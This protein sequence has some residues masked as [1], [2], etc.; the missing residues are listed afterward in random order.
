MPS[1]GGLQMD[2]N[3]RR[4]KFRLLRPLFEDTMLTS[5]SKDSLIPL[6]SYTRYSHSLEKTN[7][8]GVTL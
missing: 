2:I 4:L 1:M 6:A 8:K 3:M 5:Q 7:N